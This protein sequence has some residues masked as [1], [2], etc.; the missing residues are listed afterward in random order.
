MNI[1]QMFQ[2]NGYKLGFYVRKVSWPTGQK[3]QVLDIEGV[4]EG[5]PISGDPPYYN[6][7]VLG[8]LAGA[9]GTNRSVT[10]KSDN[11]KEGEKTYSNGGTYSWERVG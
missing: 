6:K 8:L 4:I 2:A 3:A 11:W 1:Y 5:Q 9:P 7:E 10:L